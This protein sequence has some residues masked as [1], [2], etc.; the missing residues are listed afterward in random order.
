MTDD[1]RAVVLDVDGTLVD[2]ERDGH[3]VAFNLAFEELGL[4]YRWDPELYGELLLVTG[5]ERRLASYLE[6]QGQGEAERSELARRLHRRKTEL[7]QELIQD[8]RVQPR[9]GVTELLDELAAERVRVS[10]ATT[11]SRAWVA[12]LLDRLFGLDR[13]EVVITGDEVDVLKPD[14]A[15]YLQALEAM[16]VPPA[17]DVV[18][19]ED[20]RN[21]LV[22]ARAA[23]LSCVVV[24]NDYTRE[25]DFSG[26]ELVLDG[27][28]ADSA[29][30]VLHDPYRLAPDRRL[31]VAT[32]RRVAAAR[33]A[34]DAAG[35]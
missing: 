9:P 16:E 3:R 29:P 31:D 2:S 11:G 24:V 23:G 14:P 18:A 27:Y 13:F 30:R 34:G 7:F 1:L 21:G 12:P 26:S 5:G 8:G 33:S 17:P 35:R 32:M 28:G 15:A 10:V 6:G 22:A 19:L 25:Q 4:P 20:S